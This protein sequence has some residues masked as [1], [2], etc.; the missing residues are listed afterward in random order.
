[1]INNVFK[2]HSLK[3]GRRCCA[4]IRSS[5][6]FATNIIN[7]SK[8]NKSSGIKGTSSTIKCP[9]G[10]EDVSAY[11]PKLVE[12]DKYTWWEDKQLFKPEFNKDGKIKDRGIFTIPS[13]PPNITGVLH[14]GHALA[15]TLQDILI[16]YNKM[17]GKT[18]LFVPGFDHAGIATQSVVEKSLWKLEHRRRDSYTKEEFF[19]KVQDW[20]DVNYRQIK[21]QFKVMG[22]SYDWSKEAFT[23]D[24]IRTNTVNHA[25]VKLFDEGIIYR[26]NKL[27]N[28]STKL[29][30]VVS[31]IEVDYKEIKGRTMVSVPNYD[32]PVE[33][34]VLYNICYKIVGSN[35][36]IIVSTTRPE[37]IFGDVAIAIHPND[38][39]YQH[40]HNNK[41]VYHPILNK[42]IPIILD[43]NIVDLEFGTGA[44]KITPGHDFN[45]YK[46]SQRYNL[47]CITIL[48]ENGTL[49]DKCGI[50]WSGLKRFDAR[51]KVIQKLQEQ[52]NL[53]SQQDHDMVIP[54]CS[55]SGDIIEPILK[56]QWYIDQSP[57]ISEAMKAV[58]SSKIQI[59]PKQSE[60]EYFRWLHN[61]EDWCISR[62]LWWGHQCPVYLM[63]FKD[64]KTVDTLDEKYWVAAESEEIALKKAKL[65]FPTETIQLKRDQDVLDTWFSSALWPLS[66]LGWP[67]DTV[68]FK[69]FYPF[70]LLE[71]GWDILFFWITRMIILSI[72]LTGQ[73][74]FKEVFC[75]PLV[76]DSEGRK[77]SKSL[78]N[79]IDPMDV[80]YGASLMNLE[81][82]IKESNLSEVEIERANHLIGK[83][84]PGGIVACGADALR[85]TL[86][87]L[88]NKFNTS[89]INL[90]INKVIECRRFINKI[91]QAVRFLSI[92]KEKGIEIARDE[93]VETIMDKWILCQLNQYTRDLNQFINERNFSGFASGIYHLWYMICDNYIEYV[94][95]NPGSIV[96]LYEVIM[97]ALVLA[98]PVIPYVTEE[99]YQ[100]MVV[101]PV[102]GTNSILEEKYP[103]HSFGV[104]QESLELVENCDKIWSVI[105]EIRSM[106]EKYATSGRN[107]CYIHVKG[108]NNWDDDDLKLIKILE[109][110]K[111]F[112]FYS[113]RNYVQDITVDFGLIPTNH[114]YK[115]IDEKVSVSMMITIEDAKGK[116]AQLTK[117]L[118]KV[119]YKLCKLNRTVQSSSYQ[120]KVNEKVK[121][122][123]QSKI[124]QLN[125]ERD[126]ILAMLSKLK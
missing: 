120:S 122:L 56:E 102:D 64:G 91:Y 97:K 36:S 100:R 76:R 90:D 65:R 42:K 21:N 101:A 104:C 80:I 73:I 43:D 92:R 52:K 32:K 68:D 75:H 106:C 33:F 87:S 96:V 123:N 47:P 34:G 58:K 25:F 59:R 14:I 114:V 2:L 13:P 27:V 17:L 125:L 19:R 86:C 71:S 119:D 117:K 88:V 44:V 31:N 121:Q 46:M 74:P 109:D 124:N 23:M 24:P 63:E 30:T 16:R 20:K 49:N 5:N 93:Y 113:T 83:S 61:I 79:V 11:D 89:D 105:K 29:Q 85:F 108:V 6:Y 95:F 69:T 35:E 12:A 84:F 7:T 54:I 15:I 126:D 60:T 48:N 115:Q 57:M 37:T 78:G 103:E 18:T 118:E 94:K 50:E 3:R 81:K 99:L 8:I 82:K 111:T 53:I 70:S 55:R 1:M 26:A 62:Q 66:I 40:L 22:G 107:K 28:W 110:A 112:I 51:M 77:M 45:D 67:E 38:L 72:K 116:I 10:S 4:N 98:H 9:I 41:F 39:R